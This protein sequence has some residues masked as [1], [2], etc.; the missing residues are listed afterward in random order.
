MPGG[1]P[2]QRR[3]EVAAVAQQ[4][5]AHGAQRP[6]DGAA[7]AAVTRV[8]AGGEDRVGRQLQGDEEGGD[9]PVA[10]LPAR[11]R[12]RER[13]EGGAEHGHRRQ[14]EGSAGEH[15]VRSGGQRD[16]HGRE[17]R[18]AYGSQLLSR[19]LHDAEFCHGRG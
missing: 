14:G 7:R 15:D 8:L 16:A 4:I 3:A 19:P 12:V 5:D 1:E 10:A 18:R 13:E 17:Q 11:Q 6:R 2:G 9:V